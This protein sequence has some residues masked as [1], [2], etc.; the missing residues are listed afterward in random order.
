MAAFFS[1][2]MRRDQRRNAYARPAALSVAL[3]LAAIT[4]AAAPAAD[5]PSWAYPNSPP[6]GDPPDDGAPIRIPGNPRA[7]TRT[8]ILDRFTVADWYPQD[9]PAMPASVGKGRNPVLRACGYCHLPSG[10]GRPENAALTGLT[11]AYFKQ[12]VLNFRNGQRQGSEPK[13]NPQNLMIGIAQAVTEAEIDEAAAYF[14]AIKPTSF[15]KVVETA[16]VPRTVTVGS[17]LAKDPKGGVEP[18]GNRIIEVPD[19]LERFENRDPRTPFTAYVPIGSVD[20]GKALVESGGERTIR[21]AICHGENLTGLGDVPILAGRSPSY[22]VRQLYDMQ[23][24]KRTGPSA[25]LMTQVV[26]N[27]TTEDM[28]AIAAYLA[29]VKPQGS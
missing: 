28:A 25:A 19:D 7:L 18:I 29:T 10:A 16:T 3:L 5:F 20:K 1:A 12:Q 4:T 13:R 6:G 14:A 17:I 15:V 21:C 22:V 26:A 27:L 11:P 9:H 2:L 24:G 23:H 8:Q